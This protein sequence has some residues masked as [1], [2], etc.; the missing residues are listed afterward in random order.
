M[1]DNT[2]IFIFTRDRPETL[3]LTLLSIASV[4]HSIFL[5][6]D[7]IEEG[8]QLINQK[9]S[10][11]YHCTYL[12]K[13]EFAHFTKA[14]Q[15]DLE[16]Y[17]FMLREPGKIE[18]SLGYA[19]NFALIYAKSKKLEKV[20]YTD[21]DIQVPDINVIES[22]FEAINDYAFVGAHISG[23][24]DDSALGH[25]ATDL[26]IINER[27]LSGGFLVFNPYTIECNFLNNYNEDWIWL[28]LQLKEK[29]FLQ[30]EKVF[31]AISDPHEKYER[32]IMF[33]E[34]GEILLDGILDLFPNGSYDSLQS[35]V[36]W[37][38]ML[39]ERKEYL[40]LLHETA[41][42]M[43]K[44]KYVPIIDHVQSNSQNFNPSL[45]SN[46]FEKYFADRTLFKRLFESL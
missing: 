38:R 35:P 42:K 13:K 2:G 12:G 28:F 31:Q 16:V 15:I 26:G 10:R 11:E 25:I 19:R 34:F 14:N 17:S 45:F 39:A 32:K 9:F 22:L 29:K 20:L 23:L 46:L 8:N 30:T 43:R 3:R 36:F 7:S 44:E 27:M 24:V 41:L 18:W 21:D 4:N 6:D 40:A 1:I 5:I 33:Q 37:E